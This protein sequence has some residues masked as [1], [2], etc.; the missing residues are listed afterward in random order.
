MEI[1]FWTQYDKKI[2]IEEQK[3]FNIF[4]KTYSMIDLF[5][6]E[7]YINYKKIRFFHKITKKETSI[8]ELEKNN[9]SGTLVY[10]STL[11][12]E[13]DSKYFFF[14]ILY[15]FEKFYNFIKEPSK[16]NEEIFRNII[17]FE[18]QKT[19]I[20]DFLFSDGDKKSSEIIFFKRL[21]GHTNLGIFILP[22]FNQLIKF[23]DLTHLELDNNNITLNNYIVYMTKLIERKYFLY[24]TNEE[25]EFDIYK[26]QSDSFVLKQSSKYVSNYFFNNITPNLKEKELLKFITN[27][28][29]TIPE[30]TLNNL[31]VE[32]SVKTV[33]K[34][35]LKLKQIVEDYLE[36]LF[37]K[38]E[39]NLQF[40][41]ISQERQLEI[42]EIVLSKTSILNENFTDIILILSINNILNKFSKNKMKVNEE[43]IYRLQKGNNNL[44]HKINKQIIVN[45]LKKRP[46]SAK[47]LN[48]L[49][50]NPYSDTLGELLYE[51]M[52]EYSIKPS[53]ELQLF[54][55]NKIVLE[56]QRSQSLHSLNIID[57][58]FVQL[59]LKKYSFHEINI[60]ITES[61]D[62]YFLLLLITIFIPKMKKDKKDKIIKTLLFREKNL[63]NTKLKFEDVEQNF[64]IYLKNNLK[65][66]NYSFND[67][68][69]DIEVFFSKYKKEVSKI[70]T[71]IFFDVFFDVFVF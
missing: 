50:L 37:K 54:V 4:N 22:L 13:E 41:Y 35:E 61:I 40:S 70:E 26:F 31:F 60:S 44:T 3:L 18:N 8:L 59:I 5:T 46:S 65:H 57:S 34:E 33:S 71:Y 49:K 36:Y 32:D 42:K 51:V 24:S 23:Y 55:F 52:V 67:I 19:T 66:F 12:N 48:F 7:E 25:N 21:E 30:D 20:K 17:N 68:E 11:K 63:H 14:N 27:I 1:N 16:K 38:I 15:I 2:K 29:P 58:S 56:S 45:L 69:E 6:L 9:S 47:I 39:N 53:K 28:K 62:L 43:L 64:V 10:I